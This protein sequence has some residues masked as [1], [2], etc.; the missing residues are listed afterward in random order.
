MDVDTAYLIAKLPSNEKIYMKAPPGLT[1]IP[2]GHVLELLK[3]I[4]GLKQSGRHWHNHLHRTILGMG[5]RQSAADPCLYIR[6]RQDGGRAVIIVYVDDILIAAKTQDMHHI[7][8][9]LKEI[10]SMKDSG[11]ISWYLGSAITYE[12]GRSE[13]TISQKAYT[14]TILKRAGMQDCAPAPTPIVDRL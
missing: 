8:E 14:Q 12:L 5:F 3:C 1:G 13:L 4:Y 9:E 11:R 2:E 10:Y 6:P 7:K